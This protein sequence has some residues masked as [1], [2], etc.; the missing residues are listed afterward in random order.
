MVLLLLRRP[1]APPGLR[2]ATYNARDGRGGRETDAAKKEKQMT[3][4]GLAN[5]INDGFDRVLKAIA[6]EAPAPGP[7]LPPGPTAAQSAAAFVADWKR[8]SP[9]EFKAAFGVDYGTKLKAL[10]PNPDE[11]TLKL[12]TRALYNTE[13]EEC[14]GPT[15]E[16]GENGPLI[17]DQVVSDAAHNTP[18]YYMA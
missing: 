15:C 9:S 12:Y 17:Y 16:Q 10:G 2:G 7:T 8:L 18:T 3:P 13:G 4:D 6:G 1:E 11:A 14:D 5:L